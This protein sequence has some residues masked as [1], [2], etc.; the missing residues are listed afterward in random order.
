MNLKV[1]ESDIEEN[2]NLF[3]KIGQTVEISKMKTV[4]TYVKLSN[5]SQS[6]EDRLL[7]KIK[8]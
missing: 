8:Y 4:I 1:G 5:K 2:N 6:F 3:N 7:F